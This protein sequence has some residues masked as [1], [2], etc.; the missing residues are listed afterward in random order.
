MNLNLITDKW[1]PAVRRDGSRETIAPLE[2]TSNLENNP[3]A[4]LD[5]PRPDFKGALLQFL[6]GLFQTAMTPDNEDDWYEMF[7]EPPGPDALKEK[8][9][10]L[11]QYFNLLPTE[12]NP[13]AFMQDKDLTG[14]ETEAGIEALLIDSPGGNTLKENKDF[15]IKRGRTAGLCPVCTATALFTLQTNAP[16]GGQGHR[17]SLRGGGPLTTLAAGMGNSKWDS[18]WHQIWLNNLLPA[19][20]KRTICNP[21]KKKIQEKLP[22]A[23][24]VKSSEGDIKLTGQEIHPV[25]TYWAMPRRIKL[26]DPEE[27]NAP[28]SLC[29]SQASYHFHNYVTKNY[30]NN[31]GGDIIHPLSPYYRDKD[32]AKLPTHPQPGGFGYRHW[33][34]YI[35][36]GGANEKT[37]RAIV[38]K[39]AE[40]HLK[41]F[42]GGENSNINRL[43]IIIFGFDMDNMKARAWYE[44]TM[45][46]WLLP[47]KEKERLTQR[48]EML[49]QAATEIAGNTRRA[50]ERAWKDS[51]S[52]TRGDLSHVANSFWTATEG[53]FYEKMEVL[54]QQQLDKNSLAALYKEWL[55][56]LK[57]ESL[58]IFEIYASQ[59]SLDDGDEKGVPKVVR[60]RRDLRFFNDRN[61]RKALD[62]GERQKAS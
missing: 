44:T 58:R 39:A 14:E 46:D 59:V 54:A 31:Y 51:G 33:P 34:A 1:L 29:G 5:P 4:R 57:M 56:I 23:G 17:T 19:D 20:L 42:E 24:T 10:S 40:E 53:P 52:K 28:C 41:E 61:G 43:E 62:L 9:K 36:T 45:P 3:V 48:S 55:Q 27:V 16:S 60:A 25:H 6:V 50:V 38:L 21:S 22:W 13:V 30:G 26:R 35:G 11:E 12:N 18:L 7:T 37:E 8:L 49:V 47:E 32:G 2:I 15:F